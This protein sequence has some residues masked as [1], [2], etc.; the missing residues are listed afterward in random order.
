MKK[1]LLCA[2]FVSTAL[3]SSAGYARNIAPGVVEVA[4]SLDLS[5]SSTEFKDDDGTVDSDTLALSG[6]AFYYLS[7]NIGLGATWTYDS[8]EFHSASGDSEIETNAFGPLLAYNI[9][10]SPDKSLKILGSYV[11]TSS[12]AKA[13]AFSSSSDGYG[14]SVG[15][16]LSFYLNDF[17]SLN[18]TLE[19]ALLS[20][21]DDRTFDETETSG[22][23][24][25]IGLSVYF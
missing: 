4:G 1:I 10:L 14:W 23:D 13:G 6:D 25:S 5:Y 21:E 17:V 16:R 8:T 9:S 11:L 19:Y 20:E 24:A 18:G 22:I 7:Q 12:D 15:A 2:A 3:A